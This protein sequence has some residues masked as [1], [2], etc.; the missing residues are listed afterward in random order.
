MNKALVVQNL[1][2]KFDEYIVLENISFELSRGDFVTIVGPNGGGKTTLLKTI[3]GIIKPNIGKVEVLGYNPKDVPFNEIGYVPQVKLHDRNF[4]AF[5]I[6]VV[7]TGIFGNW[8]FK[9]NKDV[10]NQCIEALE[11]VAIGHLAFRPINTLSGGEMQRVYL[12]RA[13]VR[14]PKMLLLDEPAT[15]IDSIS[16]SDFSQLLEQFLKNTNSTILMATH[17]WEYAY[18]HSKKVLLL[19]KK[20]IAFVEPQKA[21]TDECLRKTYGHMG[22]SHSMEFVVRRDV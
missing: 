2:V 8:K 19:N 22:H 16:E 7:A 20:V 15:G 18:H 1:H 14:K 10:Q 12:A 17:D 6:E 11:Q 3:L 21:F 9:P 5:A 13:F 4:P